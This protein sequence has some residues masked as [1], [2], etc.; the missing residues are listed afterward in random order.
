MAPALGLARWRADRL[1]GFL[2]AAALLA[3]ACTGAGPQP[4]R[5]IVLITIDTLRADHLP[6]YGYPRDTS[7]FLAELA[8]EG[9]VFESA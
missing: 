1:L 2:A 5:L 6:M 9:V 7:P 8:A 3:A 4:P